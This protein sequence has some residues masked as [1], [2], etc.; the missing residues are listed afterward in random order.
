MLKS[1]VLSIKP[2]VLSNTKSSARCPEKVDGRGPR[3]FSASYPN[4]T[5]TITC[6]MPPSRMERTASSI[7]GITDPSPTLNRRGSASTFALSWSFLVSNGK[8]L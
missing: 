3:L 2:P 8:P 7:P 1:K 6:R 4:S 5:G